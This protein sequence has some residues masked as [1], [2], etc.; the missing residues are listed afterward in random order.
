MRESKEVTS[1]WN[2]SKSRF[3]F[4]KCQVFMLKVKGFACFFLLDKSFKP[5]LLKAHQPFIRGRAGA[6]LTYMCAAKAPFP[7][8]T[9]ANGVNVCSVQTWK[10]RLVC[11]SGPCGSAGNVCSSSCATQNRLCVRRNLCFISLT[12]HNYLYSF[13]CWLWSLTLRPLTGQSQKHVSSLHR[14]KIKWSA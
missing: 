4:Q 12:A 6:V 2:S 9:T 14:R 3:F 10:H 8:F 5:L 11:H 7:C 13:S 1:C